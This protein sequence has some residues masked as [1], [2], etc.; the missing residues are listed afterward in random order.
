MTRVQGTRAIGDSV[1]DYPVGV[2]GVDTNGLV[3]PLLFDA[4]GNA[5]VSLGARLDPANDQVGTALFNG[6]TYDVQRGPMDLTL[7]TSAARTATTASA[8]QVNYSWRGILLLI[9][10]TAASGT[11][12]LQAILEAKDPISG[13]YLQLGGAP[14]ALI[15]VGRKAYLYYPGVSTTGQGDIGASLPFA[16]PRT[17]RARVLHGDATSYTYSLT[18]SMLI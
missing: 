3:K 7:L 12:G 2:G 1:Q 10:I 5:L 15:A 6:S 18:C 4:S 17:F 13:L 16:L 14:T 9:N 11:G 8:D